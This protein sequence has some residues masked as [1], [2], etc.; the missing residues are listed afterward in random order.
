MRRKIP[1]LPFDRLR[2]V[3]TRRRR[4]VNGDWMKIPITASIKTFCQTGSF[5]WIRKIYTAA[6][7]SHL[8]S[9]GCSISTA[10]EPLLALELSR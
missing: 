2:T 3:A 7:V 9:S 4:G 10:L 1:R 6:S 8:K 5:E